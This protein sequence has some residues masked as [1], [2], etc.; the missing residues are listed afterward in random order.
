MKESFTKPEPISAEEFDRRVDAGED[1]SAYLRFSKPVRPGLEPQRIRPE[2]PLALVQ[3]IEREAEIRRVHRDELITAWLY[4][5]LLTDAS[6]PVVKNP[7]IQDLLEGV[8]RA[9]DQRRPRAS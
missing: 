7:A 2:L 9:R 8:D 3:Q 4:A 6:F 1:V 5:K